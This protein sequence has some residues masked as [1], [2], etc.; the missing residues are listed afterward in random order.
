MKN[1]SWAAAAP[2]WSGIPKNPSMNALTA[3]C[4]SQS[5]VENEANQPINSRRKEMMNLISVLILVALAASIAVVTIGA[6]L[7]VHEDSMLWNCYLMGNHQCGDVQHVAGFIM[8]R[9]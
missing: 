1:P 2:T 3:E 4:V 7:F 8:G 6:T 9:N 5:R